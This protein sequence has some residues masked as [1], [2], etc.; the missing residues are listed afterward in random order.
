[1]GQKKSRK[2]PQE[3]ARDQE[4]RVILDAL[5]MAMAVLC[6]LVTVAWLAVLL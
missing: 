1:M 2:T 4:A 6:A 3:R 5:G